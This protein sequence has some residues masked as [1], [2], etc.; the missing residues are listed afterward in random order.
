MKH[1]A[2]AILIALSLAALPVGAT[3]QTAAGT[4]I[5]ATGS[6]SISLP[7]DVATV[8]ANVT[9]NDPSADAAVAANNAIYGRIVTALT[10]LGIARDDVTLAA[11]T[12]NYNPRPHVLPP[13]AAEQRYGYTVSRDF[14]VKVRQVD[15]AGR[16]ADACTHSGATSLGGVTFGVADTNEARGRAIA[17]AVADARAKAQA[18][19]SAAHLQL[20]TVKTMSVDDGGGVRPAFRLMAAA[21]NAAPT[22]FDQSNVDVAVSVNVTYA[23]QPSP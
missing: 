4:E 18:L 2:V 15:A 13:D 19:A 20:T 5:S 23:A 12:M 6:G 1:L 8:S 14:N 3:A 17:L 22:Q 21:P 16:V 10:K 7:P 9:T 11:Y